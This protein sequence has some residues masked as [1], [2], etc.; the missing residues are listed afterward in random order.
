MYKGKESQP[1]EMYVK[2]EF[3]DKKSN[4]EEHKILIHNIKRGG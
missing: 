3:T 4:R 1:V 2:T